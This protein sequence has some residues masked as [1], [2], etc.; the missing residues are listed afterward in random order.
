MVWCLSSHTLHH[1][2]TILLSILVFAYDAP[3]IWNDLPDRMRSATCLYKETLKLEV[4]EWQKTDHL[5]KF[6][7]MGSGR[8][9]SSSNVFVI[10]KKNSSFHNVLLHILALLYLRPV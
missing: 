6:Y 5:T 3:M 2:Y 8:F 10:V 1:Q 4:G 7:L 9:A